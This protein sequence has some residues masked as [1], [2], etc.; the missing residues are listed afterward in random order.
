MLSQ[1]F[2]LQDA[3]AI[4]TILYV[5]KLEI[6]ENVNQIPECREVKIGV[7]RARRNKH[8]KRQRPRTARTGP[9][10]SRR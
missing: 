6:V 1:E 3:G 5:C 7:E 8:V 4:T 10:A 2:Y 9:R